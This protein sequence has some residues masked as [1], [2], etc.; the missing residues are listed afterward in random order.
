MRPS[1]SGV[2]KL[3][4]HVYAVSS[5]DGRMHVQSNTTRF[6]DG[7]LTREAFD[8]ELEGHVYRQI[9]EEAQRYNEET[10]AS[11]PELDQGSTGPA[12]PAPGDPGSQ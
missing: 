6:A 9:V 12:Q 2:G 10:L 1:P 7:K 8:G 5:R 3:P 4:I 11:R